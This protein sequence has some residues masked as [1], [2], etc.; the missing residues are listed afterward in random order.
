MAK[1]IG[2]YILKSTAELVIRVAV[3][4]QQRIITF[5][6]EGLWS[7]VELLI[8]IAGILVSVIEAN[9]NA[10]GDYL[11]PLT[12]LNSGTINSVN[13]AVA[14]FNAKNGSGG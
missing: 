13:A 4:N 14:Q 11:S 3:R 6:G 7:L 12:V 8:G 10:E 5:G 9:E 2:V 1:K